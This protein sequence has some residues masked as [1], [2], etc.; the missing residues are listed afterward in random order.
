MIKKWA[1]LKEFKD[2]PQLTLIPTLY[3]S[4]MKEYRFP[5]STDTNG[6]SKSQAKLPTDPN[7]VTS[8][9]EE[10]D[11]AKA[12]ELSLK[13]SGGSSPPSKSK[14]SSGLGYKKQE[15]NSFYPTIDSNVSVNSPSFSG[16]P[17]GKDPYQVRAL[18]DF[19]AAEDNELTFKAGEVVVVLDDSDTNWWKGS[20][21]RGEGLFPAN[22]VTT[23]LTEPT[24]QSQ[25]MQRKSVQFNDEVKVTLLEKEVS[26]PVSIDEEKIDRL[27]HL[28]HEADPTNE[29]RDSEELISLEEQ[30]S[31]MGPMIDEELEK[32]D[33]KIAALN[34]VNGQLV[35]AMNL[36][37]SLM[38]ESLAPGISP[39]YPSPIANS[40]PVYPGQQAPYPPSQGSPAQYSSH[41]YSNSHPGYSGHPPVDPGYG[42][43][44]Q[45]M[46]PVYQ[47]Q[48]N[49]PHAMPQYPPVGHVQQQP[50][51]Y[52]Q[53]PPPP[54]AF[55]TPSVDQHPP[56]SMAPNM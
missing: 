9:Q 4:L 5:T 12:I 14:T 25:P 16:V 30:C 42:H 37:H 43:Q 49:G 1:E 56:A 15:S 40:Q 26:E 46:Y 38:R 28:L 19:E 22:F 13:E 24:E 54:A 27:I 21:H 18:Y 29:N 36:Y 32:V 23:D 39:Y 7:V 17:S 34:G 31:Q 48:T 50:Q 47:Q 52:Q 45:P 53:H 11:I 6:A 51:Q 3:R 8:N 41:G 33:R 10:E 44:H 2:D 55:A 20:N 35:E